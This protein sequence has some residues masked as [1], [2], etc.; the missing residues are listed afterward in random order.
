MQT[1]TTPTT[2]LIRLREVMGKTGLSKTSVYRMTDNGDFPLAVQLSK[3]SMAW[4][5]H[6]IDAWIESRQTVSA[7]LRPAPKRKKAA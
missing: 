1:E 5:E 2:R 4:K 6:E 3:C 7:P